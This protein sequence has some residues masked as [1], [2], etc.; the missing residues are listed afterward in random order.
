MATHVYGKREREQRFAPLSDS[1][2]RLL[3]RYTKGGFVMGGIGMA[4]E[5][6]W[7]ARRPTRHSSRRR[8]RRRPATVESGCAGSPRT[9]RHL[10][11]SGCAGSRGQ[12]AT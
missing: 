2:A 1:E 10:T 9:A 7:Q 3:Q 8:E 12:L 11:P 4:L 6:L 5:E